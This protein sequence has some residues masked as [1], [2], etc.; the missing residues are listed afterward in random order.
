M[1]TFWSI[2][3]GVLLLTSA[4][5]ALPA[6]AERRVPLG[7]TP[8]GRLQ[9]LI[10]ER[11]AIAV[12]VGID[13]GEDWRSEPTLDAN[14]VAR[15]RRKIADKRTAVIARHPAVRPVRGATFRSLPYFAAMV[16]HE[17]L[18]SLLADPDVVSISESITL[19]P[20]LAQSVGI[21]RATPTYVG[22]YTGANQ[23]IVVIDSGVNK[24]H[25]FIEETQVP[26]EACFSTAM[27]GGGELCP[28]VDCPPGE[29]TCSV[30]DT[31]PDSGMP[32]GNEI[33]HI[34]CD[35]GTQVAGIAVGKDNGTI[36]FSGVAPG[37]SLVPIMVFS[38]YSNVIPASR[39]IDIIHALDYVA[40]ELR[41]SLAAAGT[42]IAAVNISLNLAEGEPVPGFDTL[43]ACEMRSP[44]IYKAIAQVRDADI[45]VV[46]G[47]GND[48]SRS[49]GVGFPAC[50]EKAIAV[51]ATEDDDRSAGYS[52][53]GPLLD[54]LAPGGRAVSDPTID[55]PGWKVVPG[56]GIVTSSNEPTERTN[57][58]SYGTSY[59][60]PHV[61][62]AFALLRQ[63]FPFVSISTLYGK[64]RDTGKP[65]TDT[66]RSSPVTTPRIDVAR[67][68]DGGPPTAPILTA[69]GFSNTE[70]G[71][72]LTWTSATDD[73]GV[74][75]YAIERASAA[76]GQWRVLRPSVPP[77]VTSYV[78]QEE[79][80]PS[81]MY[82]YRVRAYD[83]A[84]NGTY[85]EIDSAVTVDFSPVDSGFLIMGAYIVELR[86]AID[87]WRAYAYAGMGKVFTSASD[88]TGQEIRA[89]YFWPVIPGDPNVKPLVEAL[90]EARATL[91]ACQN[92]IK[93]PNLAPFAYSFSE[94]QP[95][96]PRKGGPIKAKYVKEL[97]NAV[98]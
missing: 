92:C 56:E 84:G 53:T 82:V 68:I 55:P 20:S 75:N 39:D 41:A 79:I 26:E 43:A 89:V 8:I 71:V 14:G 22:P 49:F 76:Q 21:I 16:D 17:G 23:T 58:E 80:S 29:T 36:G 31:G 3:T 27:D 50:A 70:T 18:Q 37:A 38:T 6:L 54:L 2:R 5:I 44:A 72:K 45:A 1:K 83:A 10:T 46:V 25:P 95:D 87:A 35:H 33:H 77:T 67:A 94:N 12:I 86:K 57:H 65:V 78:D 62:G 66:R 47:S 51:G 61:S 9:Q 90:N 7:N 64:L 91:S 69:T 98:R 52:Q 73:L 48:F 15:Q 34:K 40:T 30:K 19:E 85:S 28:N 63:R 96:P 60:A 59:A 74:T 97:Q 13:L 81:T 42:P 24:Y 88:P 11:R 4:V 32:C 93:P